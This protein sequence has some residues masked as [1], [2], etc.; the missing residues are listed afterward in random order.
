[1]A[2]PNWLTTPY[3]IDSILN[4]DNK[5]P[6]LLEQVPS[7]L[8]SSYIIYSLREGPNTSGGALIYYLIKTKKYIINLFNNN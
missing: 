4:I 5:N 2:S 1:M 6:Y 3:S 8:Y 7:F